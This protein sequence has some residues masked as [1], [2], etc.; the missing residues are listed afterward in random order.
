MEVSVGNDVT[1]GVVVQ[2]MNKASWVDNVWVQFDDDEKLNFAKRLMG[3]RCSSVGGGHV[4]SAFENL[5]L[6]VSAFKMLEEVDLSKEDTEY[7]QEL[8]KLSFLCDYVSSSNGKA[9]IAAQSE[10]G[11]L[12]FRLLLNK[13]TILAKSDGDED[14]YTRN[15][16]IS[17]LAEVAGTV[18][19]LSGEGVMS[20]KKKRRRR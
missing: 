15:G 19:M 3:L 9:G 13:L 17:C 7:S 5:H 8:L 20:A 6:G 2:V 10:T 18:R 14:L 16:L 11:R 12:I 1:R 4:S